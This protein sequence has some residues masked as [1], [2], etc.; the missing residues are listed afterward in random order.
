[1]TRSGRPTGFRLGEQQ[2]D[3]C[4]STQST[5]ALSGAG[6]RYVRVLYARA[7]DTT[8][9]ERE[10]ALW[11]A[12]PTEGFEPSTPALRGRCGMSCTVSGR[13]A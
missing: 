12:K 13:T 9:E 8:R 6:V 4:R 5:P 3:T 1:V 7:A 2:P 11:K 10:K